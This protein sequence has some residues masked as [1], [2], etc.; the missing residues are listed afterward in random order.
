MNASERWGFAGL[1]QIGEIDFEIDHDGG[2]NRRN[3]L[4]SIRH[5]CT[6]ARLNPR[7]SAIKV[8][9]T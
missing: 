3:L 8:N 7:N 6:S 5:R 1:P 4:Q 2:H 9:A